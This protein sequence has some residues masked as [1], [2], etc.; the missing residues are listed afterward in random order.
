MCVVPD[1]GGVAAVETGLE[2]VGAGVEFRNAVGRTRAIDSVS[3]RVR[4][5]ETLGVVGAS[6]SGKSTLG[7]VMAALAPVCSG[8]VLLNGDIINSSNTRVK[9]LFGRREVQLIFQDA[10]RALDPRQRVLDSVAEGIGSGRGHGHRNRAREF[11]RDVGIS[12]QDCDKLPRGLSGGQ[13][14]RVTIARALAADPMFLICDEVTSGLDVAIRGSILNLLS[15]LQVE[16]QFGLVFISHDL[17]LVGEFAD[18][19][20]VMSGGKIVETGP[21]KEVLSHPSHVYT[22]ELVRAVPS[23]YKRHL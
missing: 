21:A 12:D 2:V 8:S 16:H 6:G 13:K 14:Q 23:L 9:R 5:R 3:L 17:S 22:K 18:D 4:R 1:P 11:L 7:R 10:G 19:V 15:R 20:A